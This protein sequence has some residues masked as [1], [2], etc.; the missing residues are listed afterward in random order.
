MKHRRVDLRYHSCRRCRH[1]AGRQTRSNR[2][3][4]KVGFTHWFWLLATTTPI[5][6]LVSLLMPALTGPNTGAGFLLQELFA[7]DTVLGYRSYSVRAARS[8]RLPGVTGRRQFGSRRRR[9]QGL[10]RNPLR[11]PGLSGIR[12]RCLRSNADFLY[13]FGISSPSGLPLG[14]ITGALLSLCC[15]YIAGKYANTA[16]LLLAG[17]A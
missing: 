8:T 12:H 15:L 4:K 13:R 3:P 9:Y 14:G 7:V 11:N 6:F 1:D 10:L 17:I 2:G 5:L 16:T